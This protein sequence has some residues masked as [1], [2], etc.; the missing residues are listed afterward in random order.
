[1]ASK[2]EN[3]SAKLSVR[4][5]SDEIV[6]DETTLAVGASI[7]GL[8]MFSNSFKRGSGDNVFGVDEN[9]M[10]MGAAD[11]EDAPFR[12]NYSGTIYIS[13]GDGAITITAEGITQ[14]LNGV[15]IGFWG[16]REGA[17]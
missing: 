14:W 12:V 9:G 2:I 3:R 16:F 15:P 11:Y 7:G 8:S 4:S 17:F 10:W 1:M 6:T 5:A 13:L